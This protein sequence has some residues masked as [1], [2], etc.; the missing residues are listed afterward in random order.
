MFV[1]YCCK[2]GLT[3]GSP[4]HSLLIVE[5]RE[6]SRKSCYA[7]ARNLTSTERHVYTGKLMVCMKQIYV[8]HY[9]FWEAIANV[10]LILKCFQEGLF[11]L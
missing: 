2:T 8:R 3:N 9:P 11:I 7:A 6:P 1:N 10:E 5:D 4:I